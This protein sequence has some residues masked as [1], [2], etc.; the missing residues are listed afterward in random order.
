MDESVQISSVVFLIQNLKGCV[1]KYQRFKRLTSRKVQNDL[2]ILKMKNFE[3][4]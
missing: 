1:R 2:Q 4:R 3:T